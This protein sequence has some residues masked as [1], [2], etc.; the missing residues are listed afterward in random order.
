MKNNGWILL[1]RKL[2]DTGY[3]K[4]SQYVHLWI[5]LLLTANHEPKEFMWN[6]EIIIIKS[7]KCAYLNNK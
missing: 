3:Y 1:Y 4:K 2:K 6:K 7:V 5:H